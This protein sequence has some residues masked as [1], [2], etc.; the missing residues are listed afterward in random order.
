MQNNN[1]ALKI[2]KRFIQKI[3]LSVKNSLRLASL[4]WPMKSQGRGILMR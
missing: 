3:P 1:N 4:E 2:T